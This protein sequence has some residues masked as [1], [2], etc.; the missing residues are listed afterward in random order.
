MWVATQYSVMINLELHIA[1]KMQLLSFLLYITMNCTACSV[2]TGW[3]STNIISIIMQHL[4][5]YTITNEELRPCE[6]VILLVVYK[7]MFLG[8]TWSKTTS[9]ALAVTSCVNSECCSACVCG[10]LCM[11]VS[12]KEKTGGMGLLPCWDL[13]ENFVRIQQKACDSM[14]NYF[15]L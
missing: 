9:S 15:W 11:W 6:D 3:A 12:G 5:E 1:A 4:I 8:D 10:C 7:V 14:L 13:D 2:H